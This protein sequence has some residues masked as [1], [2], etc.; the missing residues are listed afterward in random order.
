MVIGV[1]PVLVQVHGPEIDEG[2]LDVGEE[3]ADRHPGGEE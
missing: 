2:D 3:G 1:V